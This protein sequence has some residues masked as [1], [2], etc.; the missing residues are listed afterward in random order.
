MSGLLTHIDVLTSAVELVLWVTG[1][2]LVLVLVRLVI[3]L[4]K[5]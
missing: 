2:V 1:G 4:I 3:D 5:E